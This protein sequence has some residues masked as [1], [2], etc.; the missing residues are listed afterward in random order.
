[1][2]ISKSVLALAVV[3]ALAV[4]AVGQ[5]SALRTNNVNPN[6]TFVDEYG[7]TFTFSLCGDGTALCGVLNDVQGESRTEE[8]LAYVGQQVMQAERTG[9]NQWEGSVIF[10]GNPA[11]ATVT[12][13]GPNTVEI[14]GCRGIFCQTLVFNRAS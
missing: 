2:S 1:M 14:E 7:T 4:P 10:D 13:T 6:G 8:N 5:Q 11:S 3:T 9:S 12:Q